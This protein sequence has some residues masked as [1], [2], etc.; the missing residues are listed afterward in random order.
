M[1]ALLYIL[2]IMAMLSGCKTTK[3]TIKTNTDIKEAIQFDVSEEKTENISENTKISQFDNVHADETVNEKTTIIKLSDPN[4]RGEQH[5]YEIVV[6][7]QNTHSIEAAVKSIKI[8]NEKAI[9]LAEKTNDHSI[10]NTDIASESKET[11]KEKTQWLSKIVGMLLA[12]S[13]IWLIILF[14]K[15]KKW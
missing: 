15:R 2:I 14:L 5:I 3:Q 8:E 1:K 6:K 11:I 12:S 4:E 9:E 7:E 13:F 10:I